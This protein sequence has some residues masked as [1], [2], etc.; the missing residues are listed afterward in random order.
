MSEVTWE[1]WKLSHA[2]PRIGS[3]TTPTSNN[4]SYY[5]DENGTPWITTAELRESFILTTTSTVTDK[6]ISAFPA[7]RVYDP[8][9]LFIAMYGAT[10]GRLGM[11]QVAA[12]CNQACGVFEKSEQ[13]DNRFLFYWLWHRRPDLIA[14]SVGGGQPNLILPPNCGHPVKR[15]GSAQTAPG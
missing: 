7:L 13:F 11:N 8:G 1:R 4:A 3:G 9:S 15:H 5:D 12:T 14:L 2:Y 6:A 10:I